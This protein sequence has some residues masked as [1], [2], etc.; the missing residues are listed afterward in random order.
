MAETEQKPLVEVL[1]GPQQEEAPKPDQ[2]L[3]A[4]ISAWFRASRAKGTDGGHFGTSSAGSSSTPR[5]PL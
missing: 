1:F 3:A 2:D 4:A 5:R